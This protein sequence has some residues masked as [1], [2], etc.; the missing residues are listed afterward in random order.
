MQHDLLSALG[1]ARG[2]VLV[3]GPTG[4]GKTTSIEVALADRSCPSNVIFSGDV[5]DVEAAFR[6]RVSQAR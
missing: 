1:A 2:L 6:E 4:Q 5:R 3:T